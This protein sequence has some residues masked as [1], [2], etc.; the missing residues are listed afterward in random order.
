[1]DPVPTRYLDRDGAALAYQVVGSGPNDAVFAIEINGH[2]DLLWTD[3]HCHAQIERIAEFSRTVL[4]QRRG[5][6]MSDPVPYAPT[7]EQQADDILAVMDAVGMRQATLI[8]AFTSAAAVAMVA[9]R[10]PER[11]SNLLLVQ[12][13]ATGGLADTALEHGWPPDQVQSL[14]DRAAAV[15]DQ[16]GTGASLAVWDSGQ[17]TAYNRRLGAMLERCSATPATAR[18]YF[19][20]AIRGDFAHVFKAVTVPTRVLRVPLNFMP[21]SVVLDVLELIPHAE[22]VE[23]PPTALGTA[24]GEAWQPIF[25]HMLE[26]VDTNFAPTEANRFLGTVLFTDVVASTELLTRLGDAS[27][28]ELRERHERAVRLE[29]ERHDGRL[30]SVTGDGTFSV[31]AGPS[32]AVHCADAI[33]TA[34]EEDGFGV[35]AGVHTG[36]LERTAGHDITGMSVHIGARVAAAATAGE[37]LVS[38]TVRDLTLGSGL[39]YDD[40]GVRQ[41]K[42]VPGDWELYALSHAPKAPEGV[43]D[44]PEPTPLDRAAL[45]LAQRAPRLARTVVA[46]GNAWQRRRAARIS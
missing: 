2:L 17:D 6:G 10:A 8:G 32:R 41:L 37:V 22:Y 21:E 20:W 24:L 44:A 40:A 35:R 19:D 7:I 14:V 42:G 45:R 1:M 4:M 9:A 12:P 46:T 25:D 34:A 26:L 15:F 36:E 16:W 13:F 29:V 43:A 39:V 30:V 28:R 38:R 3:P 5:I 27:Y 33:C 11:V 18:A 23:L 31:F